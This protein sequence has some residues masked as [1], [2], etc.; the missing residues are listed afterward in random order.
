MSW[1]VATSLSEVKASEKLREAGHEV[2]L[3]MMRTRVVEDGIVRY[4]PEKLFPE[5]L[6]VRDCENWGDVK[7]TR[8]VGTV[9]TAVGLETPAL[10]P[11]ETLDIIRNTE[12]EDGYVV[13][14]KRPRF[15]R[16]QR[17]RIEKGLHEGEIGLYAGSD[18]L[19]RERVLLSILGRTSP[20]S[21]GAGSLVSA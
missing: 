15:S 14:P 13:L 18:S 5:Y 9:L 19:E 2:Y 21:V 3:P 8:H 4:V 6:F 1:L 10:L 17:V 11:D 12:D 7:R 20:I 16:N